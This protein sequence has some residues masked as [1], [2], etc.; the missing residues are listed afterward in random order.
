MLIVISKV[1]ELLL[2]KPTIAKEGIARATELPTGNLP[3][4]RLR[5]LALTGKIYFLF[6]V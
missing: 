6:Y 4:C 3:D 5:V 1:S 2:Q